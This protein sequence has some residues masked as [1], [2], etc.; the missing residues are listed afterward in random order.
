MLKILNT[1]IAL[2]KFLKNL[3]QNKI[4]IAMLRLEVSAILRRRRFF[5]L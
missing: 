2:K 1:K 5:C 3:C 4:C